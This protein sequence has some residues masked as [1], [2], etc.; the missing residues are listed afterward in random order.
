MHVQC[1]A[2]WAITMREGRGHIATQTLETSTDREQSDGLKR[3]DRMTA[4]EVAE[5]LD[6]TVSAVQEWGR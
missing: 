2:G 1:S 3:S 5:L 4:R 6:V